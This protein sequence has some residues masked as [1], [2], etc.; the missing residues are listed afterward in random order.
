M[1]KTITSANSEPTAEQPVLP[2]VGIITLHGWKLATGLYWQNLSNTA[3]IGQ[4]LIRVGRE[5][6]DDLVCVP[7][8]KNPRQAG[9]ITK[10]KL[11]G[12]TGVRS[13]AGGL[14]EA[15]AG[16]WLG[17]FE[18]PDDS[19]LYYFIAVINDHILATSDI[20]GALDEIQVLFERTLSCGSWNYVVA[21]E[22]MNVP[23]STVRR[24]SLEEML[25]KRRAPKIKALEFKLEE[26]LLIRIILSWTREVKTQ[27]INSCT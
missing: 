21:P 17:M 1:K 12:M 23:G 11:S 13:L 27:T 6:G 3:H 4:E 16:S 24:L 22:G 15:H 9:Y 18:L 25:T 19:G 5:N 10:T 8:V 7:K 2:V 26:N 14:V 20:V